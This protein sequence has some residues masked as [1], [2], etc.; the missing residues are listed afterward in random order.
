MDAREVIGFYY[1]LGDYWHS[2]YGVNLYQRESSRYLQYLPLFFCKIV[3]LSRNVQDCSGCV[4]TRYFI[5]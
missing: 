2:R 4:R 1:G 3:L 5:F